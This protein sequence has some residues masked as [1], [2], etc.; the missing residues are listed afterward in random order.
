MT[1]NQQ[2]FLRVMVLVKHPTMTTPEIAK[3]FGISVRQVKRI[4]EAGTWERWPYIQ[5]KTTHGLG[6]P[7]YKAYLKRRGLPL[8][9]QV[10]KVTYITITNDE[11]EKLKGGATK[12]RSL[13]DR[14]LRRK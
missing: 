5:A 6:T 7:E 3:H 9:P 4:K 13:L 1:I 12:R 2:N 8:V 10:K 11:V 14:I